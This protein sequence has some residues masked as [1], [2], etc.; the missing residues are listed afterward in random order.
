MSVRESADKSVANG[1]VQDLEE[2]RARAL[3][4]GG[5]E[6][7]KRHH[8]SGR[9]TARERIDKLDRRGLVVRARPARRAR[10]AAA[11]ARGGGRRGDRLRSDQRARGGDHRGRRDRAGGDDLADQHAQAEPRRR[12]GGSPRV[13][14]DL[15]GR[16]RRRPPAGHPRL[17]LLASLVRL[18]DVPPV[19]ARLPGDPAHHRGA[20]GQLRRLVAALGDGPLRRDEARHGDRA[21]GAAR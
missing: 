6:R 8:D 7:V 14:A 18:L 15:P 9:L 17:A 16:Q 19:A 2:R 3:A 21:V 11:R 1:P 12:V 13:A 4:M 20:R 10:A 5:P